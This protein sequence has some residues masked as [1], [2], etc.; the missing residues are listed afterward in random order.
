MSF[1]VQRRSMSPTFPVNR[2]PTVSLAFTITLLSGF[3]FHN[4]AGVAFETILF[5]NCTLTD[6][7]AKDAAAEHANQVS[8]GK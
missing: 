6:N 3:C 7:T 8:T 4:E 2:V 1:A 5:A